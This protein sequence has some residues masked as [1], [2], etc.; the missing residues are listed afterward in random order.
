MTVSSL[1]APA[2]PHPLSELLPQEVG[3][4][5]AADGHTE[6][7][8][9]RRQ[10]LEVLRTLKESPAT[11]C[12][13]LLDVCAV[14]YPERADRFDVVYHLTGLPSGQR[15]RLKVAVPEDDPVLPT[16]YGIWKAAD[17]LEREVYDMMGI[18]FDGH[19]NLRRILLWD[20]FEGWPLRKD[21]K[22]SYFEEDLKPFKTRHPDGQHQWAEDRVPWK[23]NITYPIAWDPDL[24][25]QPTVQ[26][27]R[28]MEVDKADNGDGADLKTERI[29]LNLG[30]QHPSTHGVFRMV[31]AL[32]GENVVGLE[33]EIGYLHRRH[34]KI[35]IGA[36]RSFE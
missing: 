35:G 27:R 23:D 36:M 21:Y 13:L 29:L 10:L 26:Y 34:D 2:P 28:I 22:E 20:G 24:F 14:D 16:A 19:P 17:W 12:N 6:L 33:P 32:A 5:Q 7:T 4:R 8:V 3:V 1:Q 11:S 30:P 25:T 31:V 18:R 9:D 15:F